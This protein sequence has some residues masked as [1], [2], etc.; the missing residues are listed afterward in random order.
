[1]SYEIKI[2]DVKDNQLIKRK[3][4]KLKVIH[5]NSGTPSR[6]D[7]RKKIA[8]MESIDEK[9]VFIKKIKTFFGARYSYAYANIYENEEIAVQFEPTYIKIRN[10]PKEEREKAWKEIKEMKRKRKKKKK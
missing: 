1:M 3:E 5:P 7:L 6:V 4:Y 8:A 9:L 10:L 2:T